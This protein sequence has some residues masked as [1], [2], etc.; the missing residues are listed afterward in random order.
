MSWHVHECIFMLLSL[1]LFFLGIVHILMPIQKNEY[2]KAILLF[3]YA[4]KFQKCIYKSKD[5]FFKLNIDEK[6]KHIYFKV[7]QIIVN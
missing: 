5:L 7:S 4:S 6:D 1:S 3:K 2:Q